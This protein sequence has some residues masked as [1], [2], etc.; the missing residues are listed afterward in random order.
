MRT[1]TAAPLASLALVVL[2]LAGCTAGPDA[3]DDERGRV[4]A[5]PP[6]DLARDEAAPTG[7]VRD[8]ATDLQA[9]WSVVMTD[10]DVPLVSLRDS[11]DVLELADDGPR[12]PS[13]RWTASGTAARAGCSDWRSRTTTCSCTP[14]ARTATG[15][16][17]TR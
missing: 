4:S 3:E 13:E 14:P 2:A 10:A 15:S 17:A 1:R 6:S 8:V 16:S 7:A 11:G 5:S 9:P 12:A